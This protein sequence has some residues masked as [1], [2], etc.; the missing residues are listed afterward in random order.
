MGYFRFFPLYKRR[1]A[2]STEPARHSETTGV[3]PE[4]A[5]STTPLYYQQPTPT[6][7][8]TLTGLHTSHTSEFRVQRLVQQHVKTPT[9]VPYYSEQPIYPGLYHPGDP[10]MLMI[11]PRR[12]ML[13]KKCATIVAGDPLHDSSTKLR[14]QTPESVS[15]ISPP[16]GT[17]AMVDNGFHPKVQSI[18]AT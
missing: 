12:D 11:P 13:H 10:P 18:S 3:L 15:G 8:D 1:K 6:T 17:V 4:H 5:T 14:G 9:P 7:V 2:G 16:V